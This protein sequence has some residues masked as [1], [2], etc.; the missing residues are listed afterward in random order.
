MEQN[1]K[2]LLYV[3]GG[4]A[5]TISAYFG[6]SL[7]SKNKNPSFGVNDNSDKKDDSTNNTKTGIDEYVSGTA[8]PSNEKYDLEIGMS[9]QKIYVLQSALKNLGCYDGVL[10]G[11]F[12]E[13]TYKAISSCSEW[14]WVTLGSC[15]VVGNYICNVDYGMWQ[16]ITNRAKQKGWNINTAW[17]EAKKLWK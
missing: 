15:S 6:Y 4:L 10:D 13:K 12:G 2:N 17:T 8:K 16:T 5:V 14:G 9:G 1:S 11:E 7:L 3:F